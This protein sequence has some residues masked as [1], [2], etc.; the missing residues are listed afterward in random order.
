ML[1]YHPLWTQANCLQHLGHFGHLKDSDA[2]MERSLRLVD[3]HLTSNHPV[4][5]DLLLARA[6]LHTQAGDYMPVHIL[7]VDCQ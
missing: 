4:M 6:R 5:A 3:R 2:T 1:V 7:A